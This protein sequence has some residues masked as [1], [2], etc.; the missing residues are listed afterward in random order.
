MIKLPDECTKCKYMYSVTERYCCRKYLGYCLDVVVLCRIQNE[1]D[2]KYESNEDF[3]H[4][5]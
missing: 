3:L 1:V 4:E 2:D 5:D